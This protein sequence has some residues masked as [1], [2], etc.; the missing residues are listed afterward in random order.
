MRISTLSWAG[1]CSMLALAASVL[2]AQP[3]SRSSGS[4]DSIPRELVEALLRQSQF[5]GLRPEFTIGRI[6]ASL[7]PFLYVPSN[8]RVLGGVSASSG[9]TVAFVV[10]GM[11]IEEVRATYTREQPKLGWTPPPTIEDM[12]GWGFMPS[13]GAYGGASGLEYCH[14]GQ[15]LQITPMPTPGGMQILATVTNFGG[16]CTTRSAFVRL[17]TST[18]TLLP[19][20]E[21]PL[22]STMNG[23]ACFGASTISTG[24]TGTSERLETTLSP[25]QLL[26]QFAKELGDSGWRQGAAA[27]GARRMWTRPDSIGVRELTLTAIPIAGTGCQDVTMNVRRVPKPQ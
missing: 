14:V 24:M 2:A 18:T 20:L 26:E 3:S 5:G 10:P 12:R 9:T 6:P 27:N 23:R 16:R 4:P 11:S 7:A 13:G 25:G 1:A 22:G 19:A 15:S 17:P 21:N 8:A